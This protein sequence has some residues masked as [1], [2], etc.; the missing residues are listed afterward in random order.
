MA[1]SRHRRFPLGP[2]LVVALLS[3]PAGAVVTPLDFAVKDA[4]SVAMVLLEEGVLLAGDGQPVF[5][6]TELFE[7]ARWLLWTGHADHALAVGDDGAWLSTEGGCHWRR[8]SGAVDGQRVVGA[9][10]RQLRCTA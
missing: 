9:V 7:S 1:R 3:S 6:C 8:T 4:T 2:T 10:Q 5:V